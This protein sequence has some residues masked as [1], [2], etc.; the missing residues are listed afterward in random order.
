MS[1]TG[2]DTS[3][4]SGDG[5]HAAGGE[6]HVFF[7]GDQRLEGLLEWP[8]GSG[9]G[10]GPGPL[11]A[12]PGGRGDR[13]RAPLGGVVVAHPLSTAGG[14]MVQPV[15]YRIAQACRQSGLATLR[16]NFRGV[17]KS[18]GVFNG[19][20][21]YRDVEAAAAF[22]RG[23]LAAADGSPGPDAETPPVALAGYSFGSLMAARAAVGPVPVRALVLVGFVV[24]WPQLPADTFERLRHFRG[25]V[26]AVSA[27]HDN[28]GYPDEVARVLGGLGLDL[29]LEVIRGAD[30]FL[31]GKQREA[32]EVVAR[33]LTKHLRMERYSGD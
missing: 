11:A 9:Q 19:T 7:A 20:E 30:H 31:D 23:R 4:G 18:G 21:E 27:E 25:P 6:G 16:F 2:S 13:P 12:G 5:G 14:T 32:A 29:T 24:S 33:F 26:L 17:G 15:V 8:E 10:E 28:L 1:T 22:L 3:S